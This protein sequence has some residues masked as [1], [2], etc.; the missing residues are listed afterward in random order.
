[1]EGDV[2]FKYSPLDFVF[3]ALGLLFFLSDIALD[4]V[5]V[6]HFYHDGDL[7]CLGLLVGFLVGSS[8]L[9]QLFS[10]LWYRYEDFER[11]TCAERSVSTAGLRGLHLLQLGVYLRYVGVLEVALCSLWS[12]RRAPRNTAVYLSH[13]LA[14]LRLVETFSESSP[15]LVLMLTVMLRSGDWRD[16]VTMLK[17][18]GSASAI[19]CSVTLYHRSLRS[20]LPDKAQQGALSSLLYFAWNLL[21]IFPRLVALALFAHALPCYIFT[22]FLCC[23]A[24]L[25]FLAWCAGTSLMDSAGGEWLYRATVGLIWYFSWF[26][27]TEGNTARRCILY[28][29]WM[30]ADLVLLCGLACWRTLDAPPG[31]AVL[32]PCIAIVMSGVVLGVYLG[33]ILLKLLYYRFCHPK[34]ESSPSARSSDGMTDGEPSPDLLKPMKLCAYAGDVSNITVDGDQVDS[35]DLSWLVRE[36]S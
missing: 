7:V 16:P 21:L 2:S 30:L 15:Q 19:A 22:H 11:H 9:G 20:F 29:T 8:V 4:V 28:H 25:L 12:K 23:W 34:L 13:D 31:A 35:R 10:W 33:G 6:V 26:N 1:M 3:T 18:L 17:A 5:A 14:L 36:V 24:V 27:V 32:S